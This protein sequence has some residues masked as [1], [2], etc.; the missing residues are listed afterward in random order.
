MTTDIVTIPA[1]A[2]KVFNKQKLIVAAT[3]VAGF[4]VGFKLVDMAASRSTA[5]IPDATV[6]TP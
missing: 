2:E 1:A 5:E 4:L 6:E 3:L